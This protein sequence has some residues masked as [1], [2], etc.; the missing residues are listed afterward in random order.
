LSPTRN[1]R[2]FLV[3]LRYS[4]HA[5]NS[6]YEAFGPHIEA[7][8]LTAPVNFR[9]TLGRFG[10]PLSLAFARVTRHPWYSIGAHLTEWHTLARM[11]ASR[12][13]IFHVLY[14]DTDL[15]LLRRAHHV[16]RNRL[17]A[18]FH[19]PAEDLRKLGSIERVAR[20]L[21]AAILVSETQRRYF[22]EFMPHTRVFVVPHGVNTRFFHPPAAPPGSEVCITVGSHLRDFETLRD[23]IRLIWE[24]RPEMRF[25]A[26]GTRSDKKSWFPDLPDERIRFLDR[27]SDSDLLSAYQGSSLALFA[28]RQ[29]TANNAMLEA[30]ACGLPLVATDIGGIA[31]YVTPDTGVLCPPRDARALADAAIQLLE[32]RDRRARMSRASRDAAIALDFSNVAARMA[33][34][35]RRV[36]EMN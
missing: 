11:A 18:S 29:A 23:A 7:E 27:I 32:N 9:W 25:L 1:S 16:T 10:W 4:H 21:S 6:G 31:E 30:M 33:D 35:Y 20:H 15:W 24:A 36:L 19:Q 22:E 5:R 3:G 2:I 28:F 12:R 13:C 14:G 26:V 8:A 34:V 17:V